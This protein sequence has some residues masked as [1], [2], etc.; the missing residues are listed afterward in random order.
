MSTNYGYIDSKMDDLILE[1]YDRLER[2][3]KNLDQLSTVVEKS[4]AY[5][6]S[7]NADLFNKKYENIK[8]SY[9]EYTDYIEMFTK[10]LLEAKKLNTT[11][12]EEMLSYIEVE[13]GNLEDRGNI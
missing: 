5:Y 6:N 9:K 8:M 3:K 13:K 11:T 10:L 1:G 2:I 12:T 7:F 4:S